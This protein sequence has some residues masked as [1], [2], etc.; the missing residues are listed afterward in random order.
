MLLVMDSLERAS[1]SALTK[2]TI[3]LLVYVSKTN[4]YLDY[5]GYMFRP[6]NR[7]SSGP[8]SNNCKVLL[9]NW[10]PNIYSYIQHNTV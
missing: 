5:I 6:V 10:D 8:Q 1:R 3:K 9:R 7:S 4:I 2:Y